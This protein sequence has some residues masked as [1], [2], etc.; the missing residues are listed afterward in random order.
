MAPNS[1]ELK[2]PLPPPKL[3]H[4]MQKGPRHVAFA[5]TSNMMEDPV[6]RQPTYHNK[7]AAYLLPNE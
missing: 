2:Y 5:F 6:A 4:L 3:G 1:A 7:D